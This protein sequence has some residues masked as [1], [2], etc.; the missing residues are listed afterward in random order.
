MNFGQPI[1]R[2]NYAKILVGFTL[3]WAPQGRSDY[4]GTGPDNWYQSIR[5]YDSVDFMCLVA[6]RIS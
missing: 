4:F 3:K 2:G 5:F 6:F 1:F